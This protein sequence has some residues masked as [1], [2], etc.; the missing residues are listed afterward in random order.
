MGALFSRLKIFRKER[1]KYSDLNREFDNILNNGQADKLGGYSTSIGEMQTS[2]APTDA[3]GSPSLATSIAGELARIRY[4]LRQLIGGAQWYTDPGRCLAALPDDL[5]GGLAFDGYTTT[6]VLGDFIQRGGIINALQRSVADVV[7]ADFDTTNKKFGNASYILG[8][9][10]ILAFPG[11]LTNVGTLSAHFRNLTAGD[12]IA[13]NPLLGLELFLDSNGY[14]NAKMTKQTAAGSEI[15]KDTSSVVGGTSRAGN[16]AWQHVTM[17]WATSGALGA[18]ADLL[19]LMRDV[20]DEAAPV[21]GTFLSSP[22]RGGV[23][24]FG[25]K[26]NDPATWDKFSSMKVEPDAEA[27]NAWTK[28]VTNGNAHATTGVAN[29]LFTVSTDTAAFYSRATN[30][31]LASMTFEIKAKVTLDNAVT[32]KIVDQ[33]MTR[34][35]N[36]VI[37]PN[38]TMIQNSETGTSDHQR[39]F[40][41]DNTDFNVYRLTCSGSPNPTYKLYLNGVLIYSFVDSTATNGASPDTCQF[42]TA[43]TG[44]MIVEYVAYHGAAAVPPVAVSTSGNLDDI[45][46][47]KAILADGILTQLKNNSYRSVFGTDP[48]LGPTMPIPAVVNQS[49]GDGGAPTDIVGSDLYYPFDGK[50]KVLVGAM[51]TYVG[52]AT[53]GTNLRLTVDDVNVLTSCAGLDGGTIAFLA[54]LIGPVG[55]RKLSLTQEGAGLGGAPGVSS[56]YAVY[57]FPRG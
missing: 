31:N 55:L 6:D 25:A 2:T 3:S 15:A 18:G 45:S 20:V 24:F 7:A 21:S 51:G 19:S 16:V 40:T 23:W 9:G 26:R 38:Y 4:M 52:S 47:S 35:V 42:S 37:A 39:K 29:G 5:I 8:A 17:K 54:E 27:V 22:G 10:N 32:V 43:G 12:Y 41:V 49:F 57:T 56:A 34:A 13:Y 53:Y 14:I 1:L 44:S 28:T 11:K 46:M 48:K 33:S 50:S 30:I 36:L